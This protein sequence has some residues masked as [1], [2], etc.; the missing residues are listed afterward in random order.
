M[1]AGYRVH[2]ANPAAMQQYEGIKH[3]GDEHDARWLAHLLRLKILP[4]GYIYPRQAHGVRDLMRRRMQAGGLPQPAAAG[5]ADP[6]HA[7]PRSRD[8][9]Q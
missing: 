8:A 7:Q 1:E 6:D 3:T 4:E 9:G 2:L 5:H